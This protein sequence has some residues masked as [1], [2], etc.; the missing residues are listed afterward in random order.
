M[1][2]S[3]LT[4][5]RSN[6]SLASKSSPCP[7]SCR[8]LPPGRA[9]AQK[10]WPGGL[11]KWVVTA[12]LLASAPHA[13]PSGT[14]NKEGWPLRLPWHLSLSSCPPVP[15]GSCQLSRAGADVLFLLYPLPWRQPLVVHR[16]VFVE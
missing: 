13:D 1:D 5:F 8:A 10:Q 7:G 3:R 9:L 4:P 16:R 14:H 11:S 2:A 12:D 15:M 6:A